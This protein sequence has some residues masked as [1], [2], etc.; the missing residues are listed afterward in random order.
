MKTLKNKNTTKEE[1]SKKVFFLRRR[2][3]ELK[4]LE[5]EHIVDKKNL[6]V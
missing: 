6:F 5:T 1:L 3:N 4:N 2:L